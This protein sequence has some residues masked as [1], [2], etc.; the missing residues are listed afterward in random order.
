MLDLRPLLRAQNYV[1]RVQ[2]SDACTQVM[3]KDVYVNREVPP[4]EL[5]ASA[6]LKADRYSCA[7]ASARAKRT[8]SSGASSSCTSRTTRRPR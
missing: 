4:Q 1:Y 8:W 6:F 3:P 7:G 2:H 5:V